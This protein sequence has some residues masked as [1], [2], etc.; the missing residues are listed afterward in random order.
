MGLS[1]G[2]VTSPASVSSEGWG[3][4]GRLQQR[5][6]YATHLRAAI[7]FKP[8]AGTDTYMRGSLSVGRCSPCPTPN[9]DASHPGL[10]RNRPVRWFAV[11]SS[12]GEGVRLDWLRAVRLVAICSREGSAV[13]PVSGGVRARKWRFC[14]R[15]PARRSQLTVH[16]KGKRSIPRLA[17]TQHQYGNPD[18]SMQLMHAVGGPALS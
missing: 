2:A 12:D 8:H 16:F 14:P 10:P 9:V 7:Q 3:A 17:T 15:P 6:L 13:C 5:L 4:V 1:R 11:S 18:F